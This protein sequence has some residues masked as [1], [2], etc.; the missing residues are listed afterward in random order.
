[1]PCLLP[2]AQCE[3]GWDETLPLAR[4]QDRGHQGDE[5]ACFKGMILGDKAQNGIKLVGQNLL[6]KEELV[7]V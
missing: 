4:R 3:L 6:S 2:G 1:M 5:D 7:Q